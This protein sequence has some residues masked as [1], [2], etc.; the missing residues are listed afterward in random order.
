MLLD[1]ADEDPAV[2]ALHEAERL[3]GLRAEPRRDQAAVRPELERQ[4]EDRGERFLRR[5]LDVLAAAGRQAGEEGGERRNGGVEPGLE[6]RLVAERLQRR[7]LGLRGI[8][9]QRR[10]AAGVPQRPDRSRGSRACGP[11]SPNGA[12]DVITRRG[13]ARREPVV[14]EAVGGHVGRVDVVDEQV[15]VVDQP[16]ERGTPAWSGRGRASRRACWRSGR[17]RGRS[18]R[19]AASPPGTGP[20]WRA[21]SPP[22]GGSILTTS[23]PRSASSLV[24]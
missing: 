8:A 23:A 15:G 22:A 5:H 24:A 14:V 17:G 4:L 9:V 13:I 10:H 19:D 21:R 12:I 18:A 6:A 3:D 16:V 1:A 7:Q 11:S 2:A 20:R